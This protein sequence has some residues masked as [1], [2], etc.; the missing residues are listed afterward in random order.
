[1]L[2]GAHNPDACERLAGTVGTFAYEDLH[3]VVGAMADKDH[4]GMAEGLPEADRVFTGE[5]DVD[6]AAE[7]GA[8]VVRV[9]DVAE[10]VRAVEVAEAA[11]AAGQGGEDDRA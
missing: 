10:R 8:D 5:R 4:R 6:R 1:V 2:D 11:G 7:R 3:L 9:N